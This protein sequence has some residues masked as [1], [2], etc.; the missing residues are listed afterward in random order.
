MTDTLAQ[1]QKQFGAYLLSGYPKLGL[2]GLPM[3]SA[4][5]VVGNGTQENICLPVTPGSKDHGSDGVMQW[6]QVRL[7]QMQAFC[8]KNFTRWDTLEAQAA[9]FLYECRNSYPDLWK[10][11][12]AG[13]KTIP[14]LTANVCNIYERPAAASAMLDKRIK[15][16]EDAHALLIDAAPQ[17]PASA[18]VKAAAGT[19]VATVG[20]A[21]AAHAS[22]L[23][24][25]A[26]AAIIGAGFLGIVILAVI[27]AHKP[28]PSEPTK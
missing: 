21:V 17:P 5:A 9:F 15:Y 20:A 18:P 3:A 11:M 10:D 25:W 13:S 1:R 24:H 22:G 14:T 26:G 6:R 28:H 7:T 12:I 16:A 27:D 2:P 4:C 8:V 19:A 23:P